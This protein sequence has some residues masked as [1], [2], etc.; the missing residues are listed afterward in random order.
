MPESELETE[1]VTV[2]SLDH[3]HKI[4][5]EVPSF[6]GSR[7]STCCRERQDTVQETWQHCQVCE[8]QN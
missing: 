5:L 7:R 6:A 3:R 4:D 1:P 2:G 8:L